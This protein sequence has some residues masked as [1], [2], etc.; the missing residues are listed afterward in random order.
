[1]SNSSKRFYPVP[2]FNQSND[3][4]I[5]PM[6]KSGFVWFPVLSQM[7]TEGRVLSEIRFPIHTNEILIS[8]DTKH[9]AFIIDEQVW[10]SSYPQAF[11]LEFDKNSKFIPEKFHYKGGY[12]INILL[13][14]AESVYEIAPS[15]LYWQE[16]N[17]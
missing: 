13:S 8:P 16:K 17:I 4:I 12:V 10:V 6:I 14:E 2:A 3:N 7:D 1:F 11:T 15:Y 5:I 9:V